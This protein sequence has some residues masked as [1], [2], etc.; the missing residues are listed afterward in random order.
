MT[1]GIYKITNKIT[2][3][4]YIGASKD[5]ENRFYQHSHNNS[6]YLGKIIKKYG[7]ENFKFEILKECSIDEFYYEERK[8]I[9]KDNTFKKGYNK[10]PGGE[11]NYNTTGFYRVRK[12]KSE[13]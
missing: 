2:K 4:S 9:K 3:E 10:T 6:T 5:I 13:N 12:I 8:Y 1:C 11:H 7:V